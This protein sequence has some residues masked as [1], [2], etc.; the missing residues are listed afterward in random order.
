MDTGPTTTDTN[1]DTPTT[2]REGED[3]LH[4]L[5]SPRPPEELFETEFIDGPVNID[6]IR[7]DEEVVDPLEASST[8][9]VPRAT[10][11]ESQ[12]ASTL[13][14]PLA[15][16]PIVDVHCHIHG[17]SLSKSKQALKNFEQHG[18][19]N[20]QDLSSQKKR[21]AYVKS[22][23]EYRAKSEEKYSV[24]FVK[25]R[26]F[27]H[28]NFKDD[29]WVAKKILNSTQRFQDATDRHD[30]GNPVII[31]PMLLD[32]G[33]T[34]LGT[35]A[36]SKAAKVKGS[37][38][39]MTEPDARKE[40]IADTKINYFSKTDRSA[41]SHR[42]FTRDDG[43]LKHQIEIL[44]LMAKLWPGQIMPFCPYDPRRPNGLDHV[45]AAMDT[46][47]YVGVKLY[48]RCGWMPYNNAAMHGPD[49][50]DALDRR[51]DEFYTYVT[52]NDIP[53]LNHTSPTGHPPEGALVFPWRFTDQANSMDRD[54]ASAYSPV[55]YPPSNWT[56]PDRFVRGR[57]HKQK[58][59]EKM[60][61]ELTAFGYYCLYDQFTTSPYA[62]E[63]V[64]KLYPKLR[65]CFAHFGSKLAVYANP[66]YLIRSQAAAEDCDLLLQKN[67]MV[68]GATGDRTFKDYF[69]KGAVHIR[70]DNKIKDN[71]AQHAADTLLAPGTEWGDFLD[72]WAAAYP[73]DWSTKITELVTKYDNVY[74]DMS[75]LTGNG[76]SFNDL[77]RPVFQDALDQRAKAGRL[78][79]KL[80]IGTD[81][82]MTE[83]S[84]LSPGDFWSLVENACMMDKSH[85]EELPKSEQQ[86]RA[87]VWDHWATFN[88][89]RYLNVKPRLKNSGMD[90]LVNAYGCT[91]D[92]LPPWWK[93]LENF[94][95]SPPKVEPPK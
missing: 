60:N 42:F 10:G 41:S 58:S 39:S 81:W 89:L 52:E 30:I 70:R 6:L 77:V 85:F 46:Q 62:W 83:I 57:T 29:P 3:E 79:D 65:L 87:K 50:G 78:F 94:Y 49:V 48:A 8:K 64:L 67:P 45:K 4:D 40:E 15:K 32:F 14:E 72:K 13:D 47:A 71:D 25:A 1:P 28:W 12:T 54:E 61:Y 20:G 93:T 35:S 17:V 31:T 75:Y 34:P 56:K 73:D 38:N 59:I 9:A 36:A 2:P 16:L 22:L 19:F 66:R 90:K 43:M 37:G 55:G 63:L 68:A 69:V 23:S 18:L 24:S 92:Q 82:Y 80:M 53:V 88:A 33:Y 51:L 21:E 76:D 27:G 95:D 7:R 44:N 86:R 11:N 74:T 84:D 5:S 91:M 26:Q